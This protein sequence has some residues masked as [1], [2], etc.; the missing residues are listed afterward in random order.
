[1]GYDNNDHK[2]SQE[3]DVHFS[4]FICYTGNEGKCNVLWNTVIRP[5]EME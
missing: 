1:M 2:I 4:W 5:T 3:K